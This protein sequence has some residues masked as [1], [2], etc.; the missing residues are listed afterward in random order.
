MGSAA[1]AWNFSVQNQVYAENDTTQA[2][3]LDI[4]D[5]GRAVAKRRRVMRKVQ[6]PLQHRSPPPTPTPLPL[7]SLSNPPVIYSPLILPP[8]GQQ[9]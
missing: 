6:S 2:D 3:A 9:A 7:S 8:P 5:G 4:A 1:R